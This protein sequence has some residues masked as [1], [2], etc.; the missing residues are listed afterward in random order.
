[1][2]TLEVKRTADMKH[3]LHGHHS[4]LLDMMGKDTG[5]RKQTSEKLSILKNREFFK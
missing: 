1:M 2:Q 5:A 4:V 3:S